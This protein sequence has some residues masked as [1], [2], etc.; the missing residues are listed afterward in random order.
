MPI[1]HWYYVYILTNKNDKFMLINLPAK[2]DR[3]SKKGK[4]S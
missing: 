3:R 4:V 2:A 1:M